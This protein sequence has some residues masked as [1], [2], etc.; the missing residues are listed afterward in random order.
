[1]LVDGKK[2]MDENLVI[3]EKIEM[4]LSDAL[5]K[6][7]NTLCEIDLIALEVAKRQLESSFE[8]HK[9]IGFLKYLRDNKIQI[10]M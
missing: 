5:D 2:N 4:L 10:M 9:S 1:M 6:Y 8:I 3:D 7:L